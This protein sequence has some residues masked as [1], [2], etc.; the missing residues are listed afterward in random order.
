MPN[1]VT[2]KDKGWKKHGR[3]IKKQAFTDPHVKVG[4]MGPDAER[5]HIDSRLTTIEVASYHEFGRGH[6]P[7]R[8]FIRGNFDAKQKEYRRLM[9][10]LADQ[11]LIN[12]LKHRQALG[13][14]GEKVVADTKGFM[15]EGIAPE[16]A[17]GD[18]ARL[19]VTGQL[20]GSLIFQVEG[21]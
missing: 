20:Y 21:V 4:V 18:P 6:N 10:R 8:S 5:A 1:R 12:R 7:E 11:V 16:K 14:F 15:R 3:M 17:D 19:K 9:R 13:I 2:D